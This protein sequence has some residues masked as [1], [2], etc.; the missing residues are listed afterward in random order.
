MKISFVQIQ[1]FRKL[2]NCKIN[3]GNKNTLFVGPNNSGKTS[4]MEA[5]VKM[6]KKNSINFNDITVSNH[7]MINEIGD[8]IIDK[9]SSLDE[10]ELEWES[11]LPSIDIWIEVL[12]NE[13]QYVADLIPNLDWNG[14]LIG[15]RLILQPDKQEKIYNDYIEKYKKARDLE[16]KARENEK[17][18]K[19]WPID[20]CDYMKSKMNEKFKIKMYILDVSKIDYKE[21]IPQKIDY[22]MEV[23]FEFLKSIM[24]VDV[25]EAQRGFHDPDTNYKEAESKT[26]SVQLRDY[27]NNHLDPEK[28][29]T[30]EDFNILQAME[31]A[32]NAF[33]ENL[34]EKFRDSLEQVESM[35][36]PGINNPKI[37]I[38]SKI[39]AMEAIKH[40][41][42]IQ[43]EVPH[44]DTI[45]DIYHLP[46]QYNGLGYQNL[47]SMIFKLITFRDEWIKPNMRKEG[48]K[49]EPIHLVLIEEPEAHLHMQVQQVFIKEA[50]R[51]LTEN[52]FLKDNANFTTQLVI[53]THSSHIV[54]E[55]DFCDL[56]YFKRLP[57]TKERQ[58]PTTIVIDL[59]KVFYIENKDDTENKTRRFASRYLKTT[60]CDIF[61]ADAIILVE[62]I[63]ENMLLPH[64][65]HS[66]YQK[67]NQM[68]ISILEI[69]GRHSHRL[70]ELIETIGIDTL[71][72]TD[73]DTVSND[74]KHSAV[75]PKR[76]A[77]QI[78]T[79]YSITNWI[80][81]EKQIDILLDKANE[82][83]VILT[84]KEFNSSIRI[85]YQNPIEIVYN[86][87]K[88]ECLTS[89]FEDSI[90]YS[91]L[92]I[93]TGIKDTELYLN[94]ISNII[95]SATGFD[96]MH[97]KIYD[98]IRNSSFKK[99]EFALDLLYEID[100]EKIVVP[101]YIDEGL[102][103][104]ESQL[105]AKGLLERG[106]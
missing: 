67:L 44:D 99:A 34:A 58:I 27:Y 17:K 9:Q 72:I 39:N 30:E 22:E 69:N 98:R 106:E 46:E 80:M 101:Q 68:Y 81:N 63:A 35:G 105:S 4:A 55:I 77:N 88:Q 25:I 37:K 82:S 38:E 50:Y 102:K 21:D 79:N 32:K 49:I 61:F 28:S 5:I 78:T 94:K 2:K 18:I 26:L 29:P 57:A 6:T 12:N 8:L 97:Q 16:K 13:M 48:D 66:K 84:D 53:T 83:K 40:E 103:W 23:A 93:F 59:S 42:A 56:R 89:T 19:I 104:L 74:G 71:I 65:I 1:N 41:S 45:K 36:Y 75:E 96:D 90:I 100:P 14:G 60:H 20:F 54:K 64:F 86:G 52:K 43:Y 70:K 85:S 11:L 51:V 87:E 3:F 7:N 47:I 95:N 15:V 73:L 24:K 31:K 62:G 33:D 10:I 92:D 76:N 91:N